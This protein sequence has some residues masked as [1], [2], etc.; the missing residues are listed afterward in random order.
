MHNF[1]EDMAKVLKALGD[2]TRLKIIRLL[3]S[4]TE[5]KL[6]VSDLSQKLGMSQPAVSQHIKTLKNINLLY[7]DRDGMQ[8]F[9]HINIDVFEEIKKNFDELFMMAFEKNPK[10]KIQYN[11]ENKKGESNKNE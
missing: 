6:C 10:L 11:N 1:V 4:K 2:P 3:A 5:T 9:Y 8:V 7:P